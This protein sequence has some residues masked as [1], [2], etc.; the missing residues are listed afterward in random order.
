MLRS[1]ESECRKSTELQ[2]LLS[3]A[4]RRVGELASTGQDS[5]MNEVKLQLDDQLRRTADLQELLEAESRQLSADKVT[6]L[7]VKERLQVK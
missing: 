5:S 6:F 7:T 4:E 1:L 2:Q 3:A